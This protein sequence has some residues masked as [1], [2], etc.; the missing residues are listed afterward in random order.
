LAELPE[1]PVTVAG[2]VNPL[3]GAATGSGRNGDRICNAMQ[4]PG[5]T[6]LAG[7]GRTCG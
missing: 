2:M 4:Q 1:S 6:W 3:P 7:N 5:A